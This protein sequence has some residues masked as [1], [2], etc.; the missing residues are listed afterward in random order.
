MDRRRLMRPEAESLDKGDLE[1][2]KDSDRKDDK[3]KVNIFD[4]RGN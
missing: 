1:H 2:I 3:D 4:Q